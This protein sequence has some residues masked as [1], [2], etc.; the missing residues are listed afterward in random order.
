LL[1]RPWSLPDAP[2]RQ[3]VQQ[4][5]QQPQRPWDLPPDALVHTATSSSSLAGA[6]ISGSSVSSSAAAPAQDALHIYSYGLDEHAV[7]AAVGA[8]KLG[9][10]L[11]LTERIHDADAILA[12]RSKAKQVS[13]QCHLLT[14]HVAAM[15]LQGSVHHCMLGM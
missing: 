3:V 8:M 15:C 9:E 4:S 14:R 13:C 12:L 10:A 6:S 7:A 5:P 11:W 1:D 2:R